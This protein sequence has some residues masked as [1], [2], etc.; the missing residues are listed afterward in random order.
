[1]DDEVNK[2][3]AEWYEE[4]LK[5]QKELAE[6]YPDD[7]PNKACNHAVL[8]DLLIENSFGPSVG[9]LVPFFESEYEK[10]SVWTYGKNEYSRIVVEVDEKVKTVP[11]WKN[12]S[13][14]L[15]FALQYNSAF[16]NAFQSGFEY[17]WIFYFDSSK[18]ILKQESFYKLSLEIEANLKSGQTRKVTDISD[19]A[20]VI[21][22]LLRDDRAY[23]SL[24]M[25]YNSFEQHNICLLCELSDHPY[26]D[27]LTLEPKIWDHA[28]EISRMETA[29]VQACRS[30]EGILGEPPNKKN[31]NSVLKLK[32][33]WKEL[34]GIDPDS[35]FE[36]A[37]MSYIDFYYQLFFT[38]RN[39]SAHNYG[40]I[41]YSL[42]K[43]ETVKAQC[44][45]ALVLRGYFRTHEIQYSEALDKLKM[46]SEL[47]SKVSEELSTKLTN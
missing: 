21:E 16:E 30:V 47:L 28:M 29:I 3:I 7:I 40:N 37:E 20:T 18:D 35:R 27:H 5:W 43:K 34:T 14:I 12:I 23:S 45:A 19:L 33:K 2:K 10:V 44:F 13:S 22:L 26:H 1:M 25:L 8:M 32:S 38:L 4:E 39:P 42:K 6:K 31:K 9:D 41:Q 17:W 46:N 15:W 24:M 36:K 11:F